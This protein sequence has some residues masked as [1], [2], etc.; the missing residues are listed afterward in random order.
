MVV[1]DAGTTKDPIITAINTS[2]V[3]FMFETRGTRLV[4]VAASFVSEKF[5]NEYI[6]LGDPR[7]ER[8]ILLCINS[9]EEEE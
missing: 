5:L 1:D 9:C 4:R 3:P 7:K 2:D 8:V 6:D